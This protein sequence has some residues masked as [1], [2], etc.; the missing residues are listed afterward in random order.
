MSMPEPKRR[1]I[2]YMN[3]V[4]KKRD[5]NLP[6]IKVVYAKRKKKEEKPSLLDRL[7]YNRTIRK[8]MNIEVR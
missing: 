6:N 3:S 5:E 8:I 4:F 2:E 7:R 1:F